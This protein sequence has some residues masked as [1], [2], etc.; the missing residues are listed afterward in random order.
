[1]P[2]LPQQHDPSADLPGRRATDAALADEG[3]RASEALAS[4]TCFQHTYEALQR[5]LEDVRFLVEHRAFFS[6]AK[7]FGELR[8]AL[9]QHF[10]DEDTALLPS[11]ART[12]ADASLVERLLS[13]RVNVLIRLEGVARTVSAGNA[14]AGLGH[15]C[16]L[17]AALDAYRGDEEQVVHPAL[18][19]LLKTDADWDRLCAHC[20]LAASRE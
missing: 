1:L 18:S 13:R 12:G 19:E 3:P 17:D 2:Q 10:K 20:R 9:E 15:L 7:R 4:R 14:A 6:A 11:F 16:E 5:G 8:S